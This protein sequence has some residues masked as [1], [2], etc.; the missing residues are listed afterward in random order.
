MESEKWLKLIDTGKNV[1]KSDVCTIVY[2]KVVT[3]LE[4]N[5]S[6][7]NVNMTPCTC[8]WSNSVSIALH[9][10]CV[11]AAASELDKYPNLF[12]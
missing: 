1:F 11:V 4:E 7:G 12:Y 9:I 8:K 6:S 2:G 5:V 10:A 3:K